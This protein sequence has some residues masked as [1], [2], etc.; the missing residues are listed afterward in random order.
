MVRVVAKLQRCA[1]HLAVRTYS[2]AR[3]VVFFKRFG[4]LSAAGNAVKR[5][6]P[7][8]KPDVTLICYSQ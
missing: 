3:I 4:K 2:R 7:A 5:H 8:A 1:P 6:P